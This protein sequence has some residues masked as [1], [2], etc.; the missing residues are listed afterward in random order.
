M[1]TAAMEVLLESFVKRLAFGARLELV[2]LMEIKGVRQA[3]AKQLY[4][5][6]YR[7][8]ACCHTYRRIH[9]WQCQVGGGGDA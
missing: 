4:A 2:A 7:R 3:R 5:A 1:T 8:C 6:G 9:C